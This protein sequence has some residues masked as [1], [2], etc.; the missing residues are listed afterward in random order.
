[1]GRVE[2]LRQLAANLRLLAE[3][4]NPSDIRQGLIEIAAQCLELAKTIDE[5]PPLSERRS[6]EKLVD[7]GLL[8]YDPIM[9]VEVIYVMEMLPAD[10]SSIKGIEGEV[11]PVDERD[12][13]ADLVGKELTLKL[14]D[15]RKLR[16]SLTDAKGHFKAKGPIENV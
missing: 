13:L 2:R 12:D 15:G 8:A 10:Q 14:R 9:E 6:S 3:R 16:L 7:S 1:M 11:Y 5:T 4:G